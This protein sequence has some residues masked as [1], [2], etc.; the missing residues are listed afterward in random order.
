MKM[1]IDQLKPGEI[2]I[3]DVDENCECFI[4]DPYQ[5]V[6]YQE[7]PNRYYRIVVSSYPYS[8][9]RKIIATEIIKIAEG[10]KGINC[11]ELVMAKYSTNFLNIE[12]KI[13][14]DVQMGFLGIR[15]KRD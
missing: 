4:Y 12:G 10:F 14:E 7:K 9:P 2:P 5:R 13:I 1:I 3:Y 6:I 15:Y 8:A 11:N